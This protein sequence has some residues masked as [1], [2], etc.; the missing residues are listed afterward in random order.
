MSSIISKYY[1]WANYNGINYL[2]SVILE[3]YKLVFK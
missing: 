2:N 3:K 1:K